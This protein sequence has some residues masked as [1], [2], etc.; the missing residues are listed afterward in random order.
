VSLLTFFS[1][2][3]PSKV[4][5]STP[6]FY[7][8]ASELKTTLCEPELEGPALRLAYDQLKTEHACAL[9][10]HQDLEAQIKAL[11]QTTGGEFVPSG[12]YYSAVTSPATRESFAANIGRQRARAELPGIAIPEKN[13]KAHLRSMAAHLPGCP[14]TATSQA[15]FR[16][17]FDNIWY[18]Y[19]DALSLYTT[20]LNHK[21][22]RIVE[23]GSG[24]SSAIMLDMN[25]HLLANRMELTFIEPDPDR[26]FSLLKAEDKTMA[27]IIPEIVQ[28]VDLSIFKELRAGD[29]LFIDSSHTSKAG[30]D[31]NFL[32]FEVLPLLAK[33]VLVHI[34]DIFWPFEYPAEWVME[35]RC[36]SEAY[37]LRALLMDTRRFEILY[38]AD[39]AFVQHRAWIEENLNL[40]LKN[41]GA[42]IWLRVI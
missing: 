10:H 1:S 8:F 4:P 16:Y 7:P 23:V 25:E 12:H 9:H 33:G 30:S 15:N 41:P 11:S 37:L 39:Y 18:S 26:L 35:G 6:E 14:F 36:W 2:R 22:A 28:Q 3:F 13:I 27:R 31:V 20:I 32:Y 17:Y 34:H 42:H 24:Y 29:I 5:T 40:I 19:A 38:M 21:P